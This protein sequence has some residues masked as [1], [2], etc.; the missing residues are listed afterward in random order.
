[1]IIGGELG[2]RTLRW[3]KPGH[4]CQ[5]LQQLYPSYVPKVKRIVGDDG[6]ESLRGRTVLDFGCGHGGGC[7][8]MARQGATRVIG[9]DIRSELLDEARKSASEAGVSKACEFTE[10]INEPVD[11]IVSIDSFEHYA[12]PAGVLKTMDRLLKDEGVVLVSFGPTW[13]H[14]RGGHLFSIFPWSHLLFSEKAQIRWRSD[15]KHDGAAHFSEV[16]GGLNMMTIRK[17]L[18][19]V[20]DSAFESELFR[21]VPIR[22]LRWAHNRLSREFTTSVVEAILA[23]KVR[24]HRSKA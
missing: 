20:K 11:V 13:Y 6:W 3:L 19:Y 8:E 7:I 12:D 5:G 22:S 1:M 16:A 10:S 24:G 14:P 17:F 18:N 4:K 15:F 21:P 9:L 23:K 2:Y